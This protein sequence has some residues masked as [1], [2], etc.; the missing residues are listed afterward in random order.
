MIPSAGQQSLRNL[1]NARPDGRC[2]APSGTCVGC[3]NI[4][5]G[6]SMVERR[7]ADEMDEVVSHA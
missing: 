5:R 3:E 2:G 7:E 1:R 6:R 4:P